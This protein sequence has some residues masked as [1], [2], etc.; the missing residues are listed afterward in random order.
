MKTRVA[1]FTCAKVEQIV[2]VKDFSKFTD[3]LLDFR[4]R[5]TE[6]I[7]YSFSGNEILTDIFSSSVM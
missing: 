6:L 7:A 3:Q 2:Q 5:A 4:A 1:E